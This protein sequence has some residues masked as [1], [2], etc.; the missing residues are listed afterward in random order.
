M[1]FSQFINTLFHKNDFVPNLKKENKKAGLQISI[2]SLAHLICSMG[3]SHV[4]HAAENVSL[5]STKR[6][7]K[8]HQ[9]VQGEPAFQIPPNL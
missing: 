5:P 9:V 6:N 1:V 7:I 8:M 2:W 4:Q 3:H